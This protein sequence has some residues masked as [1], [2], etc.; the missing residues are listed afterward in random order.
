SRDSYL[1][2]P[3]IISDAELTNADAIHQGYG[4]LS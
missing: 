3:N 4:F 2:I 1:N